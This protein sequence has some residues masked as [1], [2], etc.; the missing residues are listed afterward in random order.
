MKS[1][2][3]AVLRI[4][5]G[6][7]LFLF[8]FGCTEDQS[9]SPTDQSQAKIATINQIAKELDADITINKNINQSN[10]IIV[11]SKEEYQNLISKIRNQV[12]DNTTLSL[13]RLDDS[14]KMVMSDCADGV[15]TGTAFDNGLTSL[16]FDVSVSGGCISG[17]T[18]GF[19]GFTFAIS[20]TQGGTQ[21]GC[22]S[23]SVCGYINYNVFFE[24][25]GTVYRESML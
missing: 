22:N 19:S 24:S 11:N 14:T 12:N 1:N 21:F 17:I 4:T 20:Y 5:F 7:F 16:D 15:Y 6:F 8:F 18:G 9:L 3:H 23:G 10:G 2:T 13:G 25:I